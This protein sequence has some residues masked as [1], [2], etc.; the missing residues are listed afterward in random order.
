MDKITNESLLK[1]R[2]IKVPEATQ[3]KTPETSAI[4]LEIGIEIKGRIKYAKEKDI[5]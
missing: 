5:S 3:I 1:E 4:P 2:K